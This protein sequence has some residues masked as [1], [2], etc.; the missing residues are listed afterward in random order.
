MREENS[1]KLQEMVA[2][3]VHA[4]HLSIAK[5]PVSPWVWNRKQTSGLGHEVGEKVGVIVGRRVGGGDGEREGAL[6]GFREVVG[7]LLGTILGL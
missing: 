7:A 3:V 2:V 4:A 6:V 1:K 5:N